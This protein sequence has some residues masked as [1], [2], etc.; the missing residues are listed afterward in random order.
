MIDPLRSWRDRGAKQAITDF[1]TRVTR[2]DSSDLVPPSQRVAVFDNDGTLWCERPGYVQAFFLL[3]R[4]RVM[5]AERPELSSDPVLGG[6]AAGDLQGA[7]KVGGLDGLAAAVLSTHAGLTA[8]A[9]AQEAASWLEAA[10]HPRFGVP[11]RRL[12]YQPMLELIDL[13]RAN[14]FSVFVVTGGGVEFVRAVS[15][16]LYGVAPDDVV[17]SAVELELERIDGAVQLVRQ[18]RFRGSPNEGAPKALNIQAHIGRRP[19]F[20][21]GNTAGDT[22]MLEY[23]HTGRLPSLCLV[24]DHDDDGREYAYEGGSFTNPGAEPITTT[25]GEL[26]WTVVSMRDDWAR[27]FPD[28]VESG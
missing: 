15:E 24:I 21:A 28:P 26:G 13:L 6:L 14:A 1:V 23:A 7:L 2:E 22:E 10:T 4:V 25:A 8:D 5:V 20:A 27:V 11:F 9:F 16:E 12:V 3:E 19:I 17:G 18:P